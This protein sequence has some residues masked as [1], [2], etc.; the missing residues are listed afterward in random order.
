MKLAVAAVELPR[1]RR[2]LLASPDLSESEKELLRNVSLTVS[3][4]DQMYVVT[5]AEHYLSVGLSALR[6]IER[7]LAA[8]GRGQP[9]AP[10]AILDFPCGHG[11]VLR[12]LRAR[13]PETPI[14]AVE[15]DATALE[16]CRVTFGTNALASSTNF[17]ALNMPERYGL[18]WCG[19]LA[20][21][22]DENATAALLRFFYRQLLP[23]GTC[24]FTTHG[25]FSEELL[26]SGQARYGLT[27]QAEQ[28]IL[29]QYE[30]SGYGFAE[31]AGQ[32]GY[33]ISLV[34]PERL[35]EIA[36]SAGEWEQV[37]FAP[38]GWDHHQDVSAYHKS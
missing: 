33:G 4:H 32:S 3:L 24:V 30:K 21:H 2:K 28:S 7:A 5:R 8:K 6:N 1:A 16:F 17:D 34:R 9:A 22:I 35:K 36:A 11:R 23:G 29:S 12:F 18:I 26:R 38:R 20:T 19:S 14:T 25:L 10:A 13:F 37:L 27:A 31:Y 15:L